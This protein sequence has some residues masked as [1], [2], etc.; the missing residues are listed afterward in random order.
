MAAD[1]QTQ[2][3]EDIRADESFGLLH[4][5][6][7][8]STLTCG[9][10]LATADARTAYGESERSAHA[11]IRSTDTF[12]APQVNAD[13]VVTGATRGSVIG[14]YYPFGWTPADSRWG[15]TLVRN[16]PETSGRPLAS[17]RA[18]RI[19]AA[20]QCRVWPRSSPDSRVLR[21]HRGTGVRVSQPAD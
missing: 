15:S 17:V 11:R 4:G 8:V 6:Q 12:V 18:V 1:V 7:V 20:W 3:T 14:R 19:A 10:V 21:L 13:P 9:V 16:H 5:L 2:P